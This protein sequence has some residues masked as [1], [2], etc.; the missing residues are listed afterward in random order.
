M[1]GDS[2][3]SLFAYDSLCQVGTSSSNQNPD[4][5][6]TIERSASSSSFINMQPHKQK[7]S[8]QESDPSQQSL[9]SSDSSFKPSQANNKESGNPLISISDLSGNLVKLDSDQP[10]M[11]DKTVNLKR[12]PSNGSTDYSLTSQTN[13]PLL[14]SPMSPNIPSFR[15]SN[16]EEKLDFDVSHFFVFGSPLGLIL[17]FRKMSKMN[18]KFM[19]FIYSKF[20]NFHFK[21][22][23]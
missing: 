5:L 2:L 1:I 4:G 16:A 23:F 11:S 18:S 13:S 8:H 3:G 15:C 10:K 20:E 6:S 21:I 12:F 7:L 17:A 22:N 14:L 19:M 9:L